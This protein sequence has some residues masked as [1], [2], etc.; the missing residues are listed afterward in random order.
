MVGNVRGSSRCPGVDNERGLKTNKSLLRSKKGKP[1]KL[2]PNDIILVLTTSIRS[3]TSV[4]NR[5][6]NSNKGVDFAKDATVTNPNRF[7][8]K[9]NNR[10]NALNGAPNG[11]NLLPFI[12]NLGYKIPFNARSHEFFHT[13]YL[14]F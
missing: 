1:P 11:H 3:S 4:V 13:R 10:F 5:F 14:I 2:I 8:Y 12:L 9:L 6:S 7:L